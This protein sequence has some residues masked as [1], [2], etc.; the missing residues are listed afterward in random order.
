MG[1]VINATPQPVYLRETPGTHC[2]RGR[3][4]HRAGLEGEKN[5]AHI[6]I[7]TPDSPA[8]SESLYRLSYPGPPFYTVKYK[9]RN[10][11]KPIPG[12]ARSYKRGSEA[13]R[14]LGSG[15]NPAG[16]WMS[17]SCECWVLSGR[18]FCDGPIPRLEK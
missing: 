15:S 4:G 16:E 7:R 3:V 14:F 12:A 10:T 1:K 13:A 8:R 2:I 9:P 17:V 6:G 11:G 18:Y 5:F